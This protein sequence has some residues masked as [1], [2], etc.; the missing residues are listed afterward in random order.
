MDR[1]CVSVSAQ[2]TQPRS[3]IHVLRGDVLGF[4]TF[5]VYAQAEF[6]DFGADFFKTRHRYANGKRGEGGLLLAI[7]LGT[8]QEST[9]VFGK[10]ANIFGSF[11]GFLYR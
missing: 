4:D 10:L 6:A 8:Y 1:Y 11:G 2:I 3:L 9:R 5:A 7:R